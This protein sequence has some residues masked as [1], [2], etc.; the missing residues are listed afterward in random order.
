MAI[1][2]DMIPAFE[3]FQPT[4]ADD[5]IELLVRYDGDGW[6]LGGGMDSFDW[7]KERIKRPTAVVDLVNV[8][9]LQGISVTADGV[10]IGAMTT[11]TEVATHP[12][13]VAN[14]SVLTEAASQIATPQIRNR[15]T[16][17]GNLAQDTRC[18]YYRGGWPCYRAGGNTCYASAPTAMN[19]EHAILGTNRCVAVSPSDTA[20]ALI[21]LDAQ[22]VI[23]GPSGERVV[24]AEDFFMGPAKD[25]ERMTVLDSDELLT[26]IR[27]PSTWAGAS[28]YYE[29]VEDRKAWDFA[30]MTVATAARLSGG[31]IEDIRIAVNGA[32]PVPLRLEAS[33]RIVRGQ[34]A[35]EQTGMQAGEAAIQ[36]AQALQHNDYKIPLMRNL[37]RRAIRGTEA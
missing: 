19:R 6:V 22:F 35:S 11:L 20:P 14:Y 29:K 30:L 1:I 5:A 21:A 2:R 24:D 26:T 33:E 25:I 31:V 10:E 16:L 3:L 9:S 13:L 37:V 15:G 32:A 4:S 12:E 7:W 18:W 36:G 23:Q 17:A 28:F 8:A 27:I 34:A